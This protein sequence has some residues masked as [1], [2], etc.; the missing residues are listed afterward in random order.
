[1]R[2][3]PT[4][5]KSS[6]AKKVAGL[7]SAAA[8][9][10]PASFAMTSAASAEE[11][12]KMGVV[13]FLSGGAAGPFGVPARNAA[14]LMIDAI[15][16]GSLPA[17]YNNPGLA[18]VQ[19]EA[20]Y[21]D[22]NSKQKTA[23]YRK[24][25]QKDEVNAVVGYI[26][27]G[28]CKA[29]APEA[30]SLKTLTLM[31]ICGT[32]QIFEEIVTEPEYL[33]R[34]MSHSTTEM[35]AAARYVVDTMPGVATISGINQNYAWG[36]DAWR[37][38]SASMEKMVAD[39]EIEDVQFPKIFAGQYGSEISSLLTAKSDVVLSSFWGGDL[40]ALIIQGA[41][42]GLF[43]RSKVVL[44][45]ADTAI[46]RLGSQIPDGTILSARGLNGPFA[47][48]NALAQW[49]EKAYE[50]R[51]GMK[52]VS[53]AYQM[54]HGVLTLKAAANKAGSAEDEALRAALKGLEFDSLNGPTKFQLA[55]GHQAANDTAFGVYQFDH[56]TGEGK[57]VDIVQY[58]LD[59]VHPPEG[60]SSM[61][62]IESNFEGSTCN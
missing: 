55:G 21:I 23:D 47:P 14:E 7:L 15:N 11:T 29:I 52:P 49:F 34:T 62:W 5:A 8:I 32:P 48:D 57:I 56:K 30:E 18:G 42:R 25:V 19:I 9:C 59:C 26:S 53:P 2:T 13:S 12:Y 50:E 3:T 39:V 22:E 35:V 36:Q 20:I 6:R 60:V 16:E 46:P 27:S 58:S 17:P 38:F 1:M 43:Q 45:G 40:E 44:T 51:Y 24:L 41:G 10:V 28:S 37:D 31:T 33:F 54:A 61:E 4:T